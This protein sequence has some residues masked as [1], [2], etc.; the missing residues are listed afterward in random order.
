[1]ANYYLKSIPHYATIMTPL[2]SLL[3][4]GTSWIWNDA[5]QA[6]FDQLK[7]ALV[8]SPVLAHF[9]TSAKIFLTCDASSN[10]LEAVLSQAIDGCEKPVAYA[11]QALSDAEKKY[12]V[13]DRETLPVFGLVNTGMSIS[14]FDGLHFVWIIRLSLLCCLPLE[15][16]DAH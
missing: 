8:Q 14:M 11:T 5:C 2:R 9:S 7:D 12:S 15:Q 16:C 13:G 3:K 1:M 4:T 6:A 10:A